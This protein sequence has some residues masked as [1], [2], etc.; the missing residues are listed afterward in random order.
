MSEDIRPKGA[1]Y[2]VYLDGATARAIVDVRQVAEALPHGSGLDTDW[3]IKVTR[4][5]DLNLTTEYH[6]MDEHGMYDGWKGVRA[7]IR[8]VR[9]EVRH[10]LPAEG[11]YQVTNRIG[12]IVLAVSSR[13]DLG[14]YLHDVLAEALRPILTKTPDGYQCFGPNGRR[15]VWVREESYV[16]WRE[17]GEGEA[18]PVRPSA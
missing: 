2:A 7:S 10:P 16:G 12:D 5:G 3:H 13:G 8:K 1:W 15:A 4:N 17:L 11:F 14:D 6:Q 9:S 18:L